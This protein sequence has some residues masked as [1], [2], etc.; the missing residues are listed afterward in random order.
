M[1][2]SCACSK[3]N[4]LKVKDQGFSSFLLPGSLLNYGKNWMPLGILLRKMSLDS[5]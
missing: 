4:S 1:E 2:M 3:Y 5:I